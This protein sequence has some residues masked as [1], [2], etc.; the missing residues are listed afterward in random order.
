MLGDSRSG[1]VTKLTTPSDKVTHHR[2]LQ[3]QL[4]L[5]NAKDLRPHIDDIL[6]TTLKKSIGF[7]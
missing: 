7:S 1:A 2:A 6:V 5:I 4:R 3:A